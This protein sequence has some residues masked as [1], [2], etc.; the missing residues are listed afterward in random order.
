MRDPVPLQGAK[1]ADKDALVAQLRRLGSVAGEEHT[2]AIARY[3]A[4]E[5][6]TRVTRLTTTT[7]DPTTFCTLRF[8]VLD[9][10]AL[11][12]AL[13]GTGTFH[14]EGDGR[15]AWVRGRE[16]IVHAQLRVEGDLL[17]VETISERRATAVRSL[18]GQR[19][20]ASVAFRSMERHTP[21]DALAAYR[22]APEPEPRGAD[23]DEL[24]PDVQAA[25][26]AQFG[27]RHYREWTDVPLPALMGKTPREAARL[28]PLRAVL[29]GLLKDFSAGSE[30]ERK[31]GRPAY[32]FSWMWGE[33]GIDPADPLNMRTRPRPAAAG[34]TIYRL[35]ITLA[36]TKPPIW[37]RVLVNGSERLDRLHMILN[38]A[39]GWS[40]G[41]LHL[42]SVG[43][44]SFASPDREL[45]FGN[46]REEDEHKVRLH[47]LR[48]RAGSSF[49][50]EYDFGDG[51]SHRVTVERID[52]SES[53]QCYPACIGGRRACPPED[54][55]GPW[56]YQNF[57]D[58]PER[59][60]QFGYK[61]GT[62]DPEALDIDDINEGLRK[63]PK[64]WRP[65]A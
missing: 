2:P 42:F 53:N 35:K 14:E 44:R 25:T 62:F 8:D 45:G 56:G 24:P 21:E 23:P 33:L 27:E 32:Y 57:I 20:G 63:L 4:L 59:Q 40:D 29:V 5:I 61:A 22:A 31:A 48:L 17:I 51:W 16:R 41:H 54:V 65:L 43:R 58:S 7:G 13:A 26:L 28:R 9:A 30:R 60:A 49:R 55:G 52:A 12:A 18:I 39:M 11:R 64:R 50:Y 1:H 37:R 36:G 38:M 10:P 3:W 47:D 6:L 15:C 19:C 34:R 46:E